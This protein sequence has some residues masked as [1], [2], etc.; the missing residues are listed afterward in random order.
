MSDDGFDALLQIAKRIAVR[1]SRADEAEDV[2]Q[3]ALTRMI[4]SGAE[5]DNATAW[6]YVVTRRVAYRRRA[7]EL[8][9]T[10][11]EHSYMSASYR[12]DPSAELLLDIDAALR[13]LPHRDR[14]LLT[15][16]ARGAVASEIAR[17]FGCEVRDVGQMVARARKKVRR[18]MGRGTS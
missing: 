4:A 6:L 7:R 16:V 8:A 1:W 18:F 13:M 9:R 11:A 3:E 5:P 2:A 15:H 17:E 10:R 12:G 14:S